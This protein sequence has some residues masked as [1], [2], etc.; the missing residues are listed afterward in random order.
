[1]GKPEIRLEN[2][3]VRAIPLGKF[4]EIWA[5]IFL[6]FLVFSADLEILCSEFFSHHVKFYNF[7]F[8]PKIST[9]AVCVIG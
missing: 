2:Q 7:M 1:M 3:M 6:P 8:M 5:A 9:R 4:Q